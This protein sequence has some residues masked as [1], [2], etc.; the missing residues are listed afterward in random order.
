MILYVLSKINEINYLKN[1]TK[2]HDYF[3][4]IKKMIDK[5]QIKFI[6][7]EFSVMNI[8]SKTSFKY[9]LDL[10]SEN[11][12]IYRECK[13][14]LYKLKSYNPLSYKFYFPINFLAE[15]NNSFY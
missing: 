6:Q 10:L 4:G 11:Y 7:F 13:D 14:G 1:D 9:F 15:L 5:K 12:A 8:I 3:I 2:V